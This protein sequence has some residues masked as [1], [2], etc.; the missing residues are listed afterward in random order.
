MER[1]RGGRERWEALDLELTVS[2]GYCLRWILLEE[3]MV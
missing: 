3:I 2:Q 1:R